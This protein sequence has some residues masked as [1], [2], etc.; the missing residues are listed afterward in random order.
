[1][2]NFYGNGQFPQ[3]ILTTTTYSKGGSAKVTYGSSASRTDNP[4][5][6]L[7]LITAHF[8]TTQDGNGTVATTSYQYKNGSLY[9]D[10]GVRDRRFAGFSFVRTTNPDSIVDTYFSRASL[11]LIG[12]PVHK[13]IFDTSSNLKQSYVYRWDT[14]THG[15][16][17]FVGLSSQL[18]EDF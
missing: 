2:A 10:D 3:D 15:A 5:A 11:A 9:L 14:V 6:G 18:I 17:K 7:N 8:I 1:F 13:D 16:S 12:H 4:G